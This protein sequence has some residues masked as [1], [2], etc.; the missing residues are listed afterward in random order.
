MNKTAGTP[1]EKILPTTASEIRLCADMKK[2]EIMDKMWK[3]EI[4]EEGV[5]WLTTAAQ[6]Q[7]ARKGRETQ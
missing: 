3:F 6:R 4:D 7:Q 2:F 5:A 1:K